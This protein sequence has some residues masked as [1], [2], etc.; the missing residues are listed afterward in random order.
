MAHL[1]MLY[2]SEQA[3]IP[4]GVRACFCLWVARETYSAAQLTLEPVDSRELG[5]L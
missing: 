4:F 2:L 1:M 3:R 5:F